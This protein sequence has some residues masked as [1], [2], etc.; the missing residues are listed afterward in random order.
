M[1]LLYYCYCLVAVLLH[2]LAVQWHIMNQVTDLEIKTDPNVEAQECPLPIS[3][4][5]IKTEDEVSFVC[6]CVH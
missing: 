6:M 5:A 3:F 1:G 2:K 4:S